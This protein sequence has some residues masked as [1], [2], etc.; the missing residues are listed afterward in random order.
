MNVLQ[1]HHVT[2][3]KDIPHTFREPPPLTHGCFSELSAVKRFL[4]SFTR[5]FWMKCLAIANLRKSNS[6][7]CT[8]DRDLR[9]VVPIVIH[10]LNLNKHERAELLTQYLLE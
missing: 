6:N 2:I 9:A 8:V 1:A 4:E 10:I 7:P 5:R 3:S